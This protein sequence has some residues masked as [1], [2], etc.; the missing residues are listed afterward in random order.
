PVTLTVDAG[1]IAQLASGS[2]INQPFSFDFGSCGA[3][4]GFTGPGTCTVQQSFH[5]TTAASFSGTTNVFECPVAGGS[6]IAIPYAVSG[7]GQSPQALPSPQSLTF[8]SQGVG[9]ASAAQ[10]VT[11]T[12]P[13]TAP[14]HVGT[15]TA[16]GDFGLTA[17]QCS[18]ST[19]PA[20]GSCTVGVA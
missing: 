8:A 13:S 16:T 17:D 11:L 18:G 1:Y 2:G 15:L 12:N 14:L 20:A 6:C 7:N 5:P 10:T 3:G 19:I 9:T 4:G